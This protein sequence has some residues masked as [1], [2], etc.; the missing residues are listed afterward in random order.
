MHGKRISHPPHTV[1]ENRMLHMFFS[2]HCEPET[3]EQQA[4]EGEWK[5]NCRVYRI[6]KLP[7]FI[8]SFHK[9]KRQ[10]EGQEPE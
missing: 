9:R 3:T 6:V 1:Q 8:H 2:Q 7:F 4:S 10:K 5:V